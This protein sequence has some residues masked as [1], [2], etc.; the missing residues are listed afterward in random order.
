MAKIKL[1]AEPTFSCDVGIPVPGSGTQPVK[2]TFKHRT[3]P[4]VNAWGQEV[5]DADDLTAVKG[6]VVGWEL[7]DEFSDANIAKLCDN[8]A[9][10][11]FAII[12]A[13]F[14]ELRGA[15]AKN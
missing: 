1:D 4:E 10:A 9:G 3:R 2:F 13:Y 14:E 5:K 12:T 8:Y 6:C 11:G 15:R 7:D